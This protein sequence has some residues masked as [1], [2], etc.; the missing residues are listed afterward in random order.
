MA[1]QRVKNKSLRIKH[2]A[3]RAP[4]AD[5]YS[6]MVP[7][8]WHGVLDQLR[9]IAMYGVDSVK[10]D[11]MAFIAAMALLER[12]AAPIMLPY[13]TGLSKSDLQA[14]VGMEFKG[15]HLLETIDTYPDDAGV[16]HKIG[17]HWYAS[18]DL[19]EV[20]RGVVAGAKPSNPPERYLP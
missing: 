13:A 16:F 12:K 17:L 4:S 9:D 19:I 15:F 5:D 3:A 10:A 18:A 7:F 6:R 1:D 8:E 14:A 20:A 11:C 2:N